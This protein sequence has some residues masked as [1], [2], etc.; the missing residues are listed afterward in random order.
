MKLPMGSVT[1]TLI[2]SLDTK[3]NF[4]FS[5]LSDLPKTQ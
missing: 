5:F 2:Y 1:E 3:N 4:P